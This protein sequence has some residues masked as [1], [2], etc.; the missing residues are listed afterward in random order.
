M[1][2]DVAIIGAGMSGL[3]A[4]IRLA[5]FNRRVC[6]LERH[7]VYGGLNSFYRLG[8]REFD[9]GLHAVTNVVP[10]GVRSAPLPKLLRQLRIPREEFDLRPQRFSEVR[11]PGVRLRFSNEAELLLEDV[12]G[13]FPGQVDRFRRLVADVAAYD[14]GSLEITPR[15]ARGVL[16]EYLDDPLLIEMLLCPTMFYGSPSEHDLDFTHFVTLF[17]AIVLQGL[18][19]PRDGVRTILKT[20][21]R[22][23][24]ACGGRLRTRC[25]VERIETDGRAVTGLVLDSGDRVTADVYFSSAGFPETLRLCGAA[26]GAPPGE[27]PGR[28]SFMESI[29]C[30]DTSPAELGLEAAVTFFNHADRFVYATPDALVDPRSGVVCCPNNF[31]DHEHLPEGI[32]RVTSLADHRRWKSLE[33]AAYEAAKG[34]AYR[35]TVAE[36]VR[37]VPDYRDHVVFCDVFTPLTIERF[38]GHLG[39]AVYG[40]PAKRRDGRTPLNNLFICGTDQGLVG[41]VG[42]ML[43]GIWMANLHVL[44]DS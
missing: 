12:A 7:E 8:G 17:K 3:A 11:F 35:T 20:L 5:Y 32:V 37:F 31:Q 25:G 13:A 39:G 30:L 2:Y 23:F 43:S 22:R 21:V 16:G 19:R 18:A 15:S 24:R 27:P 36:A 41:I 1:H 40:A 38:T 4:G 26:G 44:Q 14:D 33:R 6:I 29:S 10:A 34:D 9:V 42:T 28:L